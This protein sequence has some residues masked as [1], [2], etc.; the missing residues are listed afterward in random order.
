MTRV[1][2]VATEGRSV[3]AESSHSIIQ[4]TTP[5]AVVLTH[6]YRR[7]IAAG[8]LQVVAPH[9]LELQVV[10][11]PDLYANIAAQLGNVIDGNAQG[12]ATGAPPQEA[13]GAPE[14]DPSSG[15]SMIAPTPDQNP[16]SSRR[17]AA[18]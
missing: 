17:R 6:Y 4:G 5:M 13:S 11:S 10:V 18:Q 15:A 2:V 1:Y 14:P 7:R 8:E 16:T 9:D 12:D 3:P